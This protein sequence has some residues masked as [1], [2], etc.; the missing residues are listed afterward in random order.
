MFTYIPLIIAE[1]YQDMSIK[2]Q[3]LQMFWKEIFC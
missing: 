2:Y 1:K 3:A